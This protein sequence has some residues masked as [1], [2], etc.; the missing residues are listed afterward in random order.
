M[1]TCPKCNKELEDGIQFCDNCG[2]PIAQEA[3]AEKKKFPVKPVLLGVLGVSLIAVIIFVAFTLLSPGGS[4]AGHNYALYVKDDEIFFS[5]LKKNSA[6]WQLTTRLTGSNSVDDSELARRGYIL[7]QVTC[8]SED[9][10]YI[11]FPD[12]TDNANGNFNLY[13]RETSKSNGEAVKIDS[14]VYS[15]VVNSSASVVTYRKGDEGNLYQ[16]KL[17]KDSKDKVASEV[18]NFVVSDDAKSVIYINSE[19][20]IYLQSGDKDKEKLAGN[21][22]SMVRVTDDLKTV[23]YLKDNAL[24]KQT[25]GADKVKLVSDVYSVLH[26]YDS[27]EIYY[28]T[29][30]SRTISM[31]DYVI[32]DMKEADASATEPEYPDYPSSPEYPDRWDY[33]TDEAY[34][35]AYEAYERDYE[36]WRETYNRMEQEYEDAYNA[37]WSIS[38]RN[39]LR[40]QLQ[41]WPMERSN[42]SLCFYDGSKSITLTDAYNTSSFTFATDAPVII[43]GV[44]DHSKQEKVKLSEIESLYD[45]EY[46]VDS[47]TPSS[48]RYIAVKGTA[49]ALEAEKAQSLY[50]NS[51]GTTL[52]YIDN[53]PKGKSYGELYRVSISGGKVGKAELYDSDVTLGYCEFIDA[54]EFM[55][56]KSTKDLQGELY[57]NK[58]RVDYDVYLP[59][60]SYSLDHKLFYFTDWSHDNSTGTLK[61]YNGKEAVKIADDV[62]GFTVLPDGRALYL[63][64]YST[65]HYTGELHEWS[66]GSS[67]KLDDDVTCL[68]PILTSVKYRSGNFYGW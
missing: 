51:T 27:G 11:F 66:D 40:N 6:P 8:V 14:D 58:N 18:R 46:L 29:Q 41:D 43:Y 50:L 48:Q 7:G 15:Y 17:S 20:S 38:H 35:A 57:I 42:Y 52:Y 39:D 65:N 34:Q 59:S 44:Y 67:R 56:Y 1:I 5:D 60:P 22:S 64:D 47:V 37:Y 26:V 10:K 28:V 61:T 62:Y 63:Y 45:V 24:Y 68:I 3:P 9:G 54:N 31:A 19:G 16:Y 2:A 55:Y 13:Y 23:Y 49:S 25:L 12:K 32:D 30:T 53:I 21:V 4:S 33:D 36:I